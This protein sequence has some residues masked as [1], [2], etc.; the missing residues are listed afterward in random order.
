MNP[1]DNLTIGLDLGDRRHTACVLSPAGE[2]LA[3]EKIAPAAH[4]TS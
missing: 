1:T 2:I 3:E 4:G